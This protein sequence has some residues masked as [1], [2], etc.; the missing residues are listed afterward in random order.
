M[1]M[2]AVVTASFTVDFNEDKNAGFTFVKEMNVGC[3][4]PYLF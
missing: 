4:K 1:E 3:R 2:L